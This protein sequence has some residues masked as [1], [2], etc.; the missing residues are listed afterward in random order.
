M[1]HVVDSDKWSTKINETHCCIAMVM[2]S[3]FIVLLAVTYTHYKY[4]GSMLF[5]WQQWS[6]KGTTMCTL[7]LSL[8][9]NMHF[10]NP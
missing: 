2:L 9:F 4:K 5:P 6:Q 7:S 3:I 10:V 1:F 8:S